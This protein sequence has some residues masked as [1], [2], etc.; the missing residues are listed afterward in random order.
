M[1]NAC[2]ITM[3][4]THTQNMKRFLRLPRQKLIMQ[5]DLNIKLDLHRLSVVYHFILRKRV[6][7]RLKALC[8]CKFARHVWMVH[9][10]FTSVPFIPLC[11]FLLF[12]VFFLSLVGYFERTLLFLFFVVCLPFRPEQATKLRLSVTKVQFLN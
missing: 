9:S 4:Q 2:C 11:L 7:N 5:R 1:R 8:L 10:Q 3:L 6:L 12:P